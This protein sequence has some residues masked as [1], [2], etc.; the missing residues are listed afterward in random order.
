MPRRAIDGIPASAGVVVG[1]VHLLRWEVP[2]VRHRTIDDHEIESELARLRAGVAAAKDR[3]TRVRDRVARTVGP[4]EAQIFDAQALILEDP[5][6]LEEVASLVQHNL[7]AENAVDLTMRVWHHT[8]AHAAQPMVRERAGDV[9]DVH[10]RLLTVLLGL[11]DHDP[12]DVPSGTG[13]VLVTH[14]L[15]PSLTVQLDRTAI[16]GIATDLGTRTSHVAILARSLGLPAVVGLRDAVSRLRGDETVLLDGSGGT[17]VVNPTPAET[18]LFRTREERARQ[19]DAA[20]RALGEA[21]S[22]T[23]DGVHVT[24]RANVDLPDE[25]ESAATSGA[26]G[27]GLMR[28]EFL[29]VGRATMPDEDEQYRAYRRVVEAFG[30]RPVV[31]R[32]FDIGGD[33]LPVGGFPAEANPFLGWRAVRMC[34]DQPEL[35]RTQLRA[36]LRAAMHGDVR[37][38]LPL[39]VTLDE[40]RQARALLDEASAELAARGVPHRA[41]LP[42]G[43]M[44]ETPAAAVAADT[45]VDDVAFFSIGTNDLVQYTLAVDRGNANLASRFTPL[46]PA[47]LRLIDMTVRAG[48]RASLDVSVCGEMASHALTMY[49][50]IGLGLRQLS[51]SPRA[52]PAVKQL[53]RAITAEG[54]AAAVRTALAL[55]TAARVEAELGARLHEALDAAGI[56]YAGLLALESERIILSSDES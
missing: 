41:D 8:F 3:L 5:V 32:T 54:A 25:A 18:A 38:M 45:L 21:E 44:V 1:P 29:V 27:V 23:R 39:V 34:L 11:P 47:V 33:K 4:E 42:L 46:H 49:A 48:A 13:A 2:E 56:A 19:A 52:V 51:V 30:G 15:T 10:I 28:T 26:D 36:L 24:L 12:I 37:V 9:V 6:M 53:V 14:D 35:F 20:L 40:V 55:P 22:V 31:I 50:L 43:V 16:A 7:G 17:L